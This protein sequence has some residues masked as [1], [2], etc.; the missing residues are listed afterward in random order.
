MKTS[1]GNITLNP[2]IKCFFIGHKWRSKVT[3]D[4]VCEFE[5]EWTCKRCGKKEKYQY[6]FCL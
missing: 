3:K 5:K 6:W 4:T 2:K 1:I